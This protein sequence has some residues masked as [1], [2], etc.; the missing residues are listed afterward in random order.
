M[1]TAQA[2]NVR[3][4]ICMLQPAHWR[5]F[6]FAHVVYATHSILCLISCSVQGCISERCVRAGEPAVH[7]LERL[8][9]FDPGRRCSGEEALAHEYFADLEASDA[10]IGMPSNFAGQLCTLG[11][12]IH[13]Q[14]TCA[15]NI[16]IVGRQM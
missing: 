6:F 3:F 8:L 11:I 4:A 13:A 16:A 9:A 10:D 14:A 15:L 12:L 5:G 2:V 1:L 7:L